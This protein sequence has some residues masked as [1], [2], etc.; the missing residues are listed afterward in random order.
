M[1]KLKKTS[2]FR[3]QSPKIET[4]MEKTTRIARKMVEEEAEQRKTKNDFLRN[5]RLERDTNTPTKP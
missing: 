4:A 2:V 1:A 5:A 3:A